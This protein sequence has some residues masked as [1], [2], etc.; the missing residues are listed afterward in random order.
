MTPLGTVTMNCCAARVWFRDYLLPYIDVIAPSPGLSGVTIVTPIR[1]DPG[2]V[3]SPHANVWG[4]LVP[5]HLPTGKKAGIRSQ[6]G[7]PN[8]ELHCATVKVRLE[9]A[10][11]MRA[12]DC[13]CPFCSC[14]N[15]IIL[16][17]LATH[18]SRHTAAADLIEARKV[19]FSSTY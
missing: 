10:G 13:L 6:I 1:N 9:C 8:S 4:R 2:R 3:R 7:L 16:H 5:N 19:K 15:I 14:H 18:S 12:V 11:E 17:R